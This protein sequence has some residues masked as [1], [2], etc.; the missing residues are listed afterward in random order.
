MHKPSDFLHSWDAGGHLLIRYAFKDGPDLAVLPAK[1]E[2]DEEDDWEEC[3]DEEA[4]AEARQQWQPRG[5]G[6]D[7]W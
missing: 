7:Y 3:S 2:T 1:A 4:A 6:N 5:R